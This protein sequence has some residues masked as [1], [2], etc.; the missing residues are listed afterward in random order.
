MV[1]SSNALM[2]A[3]LG[4]V[5]AVKPTRLVSGMVSRERP[6][7]SQARPPLSRRLDGPTEAAGM[8]QRR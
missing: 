2:K 4:A 3:L 8:T 6:A 5:I 1:R 7:L